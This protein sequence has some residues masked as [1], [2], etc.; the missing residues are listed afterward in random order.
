V[1]LM[2]EDGDQVTEG[3][4]VLQLDEGRAK[5]VIQLQGEWRYKRLKRASIPVLTGEKRIEQCVLHLAYLLQPK[6]L[7]DR[8]YGFKY[9][10]AQMGKEVGGGDDKVR[11]LSRTPQFKTTTS[12]G[13]EVLSR[14][15]GNLPHVMYNSV[16]GLILSRFV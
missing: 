3:V 2:L 1:D 10:M 4:Q 11:T 7:D 13:K 5:G 16:S 8:K 15:V 14:Q 9:P 6:T 12:P